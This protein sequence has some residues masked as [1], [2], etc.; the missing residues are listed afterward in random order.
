[1]VILATWV[2]ETQVIRSRAS[3]GYGSGAADR[4]RRAI[5][6][7]LPGFDP[8]DVS[9]DVH[10]NPVQEAV[11]LRGESVTATFLETAHGVVPDVVLR[12]VSKILGVRYSTVQPLMVRGEVAGSLSFHGSELPSKAMIHAYE[13]FTKQ[14]ALTIENRNLLDTLRAQLEELREARR[15]VG[16]ANEAARREIAETLHGPVQTQ[17]LVADFTLSQAAALV[18]GA[19]NEA[20]QA[21]A[22]ARTRL[23]DVRE[24]EIR[25]V[26]HLLHPSVIKL[27]LAPAVR[28][29]AAR[30]QPA[31]NIWLDILG[32]L[33]GVGSKSEVNVDMDTRLVAY[34]VIEEALSNVH[35]HAHAQ[36]VEVTLGLSRTNDLLVTVRDDGDGLPSGGIEPGLGLRMIGMKV[37]DAGGAWSL[38]PNVE[39]GTTLTAILPLSTAG[40]ASH[41]VALPL[42]AQLHSQS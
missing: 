30:F 31:M 7:L 18:D 35:K 36:T 34:R 40:I 21:I 39:R 32:A 25:E 1:M 26:S 24:H 22:D 42:V 4:A 13:A 6:K 37:Q 15:L 41:D 17:L 10:V 27:G 23:D 29:L 9:L 28:S 8:D 16:V 20:K 3:A 11:F 38:S 14:A 5:A 33:D 12:I 2:A 19:P